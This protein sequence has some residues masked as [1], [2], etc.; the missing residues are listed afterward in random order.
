[1]LELKEKIKAFC[2]EPSMAIARFQSG[3]GESYRLDLIKTGMKTKNLMV[4]SD[5]HWIEWRAVSNTDMNVRVPEHRT[6]TEQLLN[7][8]L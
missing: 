6:S 5:A 4:P 2:R 8:K 1:M 7:C 3:A